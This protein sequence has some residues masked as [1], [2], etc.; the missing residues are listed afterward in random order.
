MD[1]KSYIDWSEIRWTPQPGLNGGTAIGLIALGN[2]I[3]IEREL[4]AF[5]KGS[6]AHLFTSRIRMDGVTPEALACMAVDIEQVAKLILPRNRLD[7]VAFGCTSGAVIIGPELVV[8]S[9]QKVKPGVP[10]TDPASAALRGLRALGATRIGLLTPYDEPVN[11]PVQEFIERNGFHVAAAASFAQLGDNNMYLIPP[12]ATRD[13]AIALVRS[14]A[15]DAVF[16]CCSAFWCSDIIA[17]IEAEIGR[18]VVTS[19]QAL[20]WDCL[21]SAGN[22]HRGQ[23]LGLL[24][25]I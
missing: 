15:V 10:V 2:D 20:A 23:G 24:I 11:R 7:V 17:S 22:F 4:T 14:S 8:R 3:V 16:I 13:A 1:N 9:V 19:N 6:G 12:S 25:S 18:P 5:L 21:R